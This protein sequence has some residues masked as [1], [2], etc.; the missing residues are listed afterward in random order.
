MIGYLSVMAPSD[1]TSTTP[2]DIADIDGALA[3]AERAGLTI[4]LAI[5]TGVVA[6]LMAFIAGTQGLAIGWF[7]VAVLSVFLVIG[8]IYG[9][10]V[11]QARDKQWM[12][13]AFVALDM[14]L[15][16]LA[17]VTVPLS[18]HG[19]VP[20]IFAFR[21]YGADIFFFLISTSALS[22]SP[23]LVLWSGAMAVLSLWASWG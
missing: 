19:D 21:V 8:L 9:V 15:L 18:L 10:L 11:R 4:V 5:R 22:L 2:A 1:E 20:Q 12:R 13:Y 3:R 16:G 17:A 6:L 23:R 7:G 14:G